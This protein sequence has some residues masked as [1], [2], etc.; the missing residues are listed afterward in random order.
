MQLL[1][2]Y[3]RHYIFVLH[4]SH[5]TNVNYRKNLWDDLKSFIQ[6]KSKCLNLKFHLFEANE[7][8][9]EDMI[10]RGFTLEFCYKHLNAQHRNRLIWCVWY[11]RFTRSIWPQ[12]QWPHSQPVSFYFHTISLI[13][14]HVKYSH[15]L[16]PNNVL[17]HNIQFLL[18]I[19]ISLFPV[20]YDYYILFITVI[21]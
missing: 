13:S 10:K 17:L 15:L 11:F 14:H 16:C 7:I 6:V 3:F 2:D 18:V 21:L 4:M 9:L 5:R 8:N 12:F 19:P 20:I 1:W